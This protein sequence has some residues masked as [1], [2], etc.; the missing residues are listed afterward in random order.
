MQS[1]L[2]AERELSLPDHLRADIAVGIAQVPEAWRWLVRHDPARRHPVRLVA[3]AAYEVWVIGWTKD[4]HV[5]PHDHGGSAAT[6]LVTEGELTELS[7]TGQRR[8]LVPGVPYHLG[9]D[10]VHDVVNRADT[11]AT[12][13]HIYS[14]PLRSMTYYDPANGQ[15]VRTATVEEE[16]PVLSHWYGAGLLHPAA[17]SRS[18]RT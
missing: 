3:T 6:V 9:A 18:I 11:P 15:P 8:Q 2:A 10:V 7:L 17:G 4:Q 16:I 13:V 14:P 5:Q 1:A 12:S